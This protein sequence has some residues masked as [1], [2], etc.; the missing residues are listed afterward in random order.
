MDERAMAERLAEI[1]AVAAHPGLAELGAAAFAYATVLLDDDDNL[2]RLGNPNGE[3]RTRLRER[4]AELLTGAALDAADGD[5]DGL[6]E[7][8]D[9]SAS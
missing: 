6:A 9:G 4:I 5:L 7:F 1:E 8:D 2:T 3:T